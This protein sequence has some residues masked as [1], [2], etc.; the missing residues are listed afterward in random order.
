MAG[1]ENTVQHTIQGYSFVVTHWNYS[2]TRM[3]LK[4]SFLDT[5]SGNKTW[6]GPERGLGVQRQQLF[7]EV[8][9]TANCYHNPGPC[10]GL[11]LAS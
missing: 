6:F 8:D 4:N 2:P 9:I 10:H 11:T 3:H 1:T 7:S 5:A